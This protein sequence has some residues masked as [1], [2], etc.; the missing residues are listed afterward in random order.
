MDRLACKLFGTS[1]SVLTVPM[2]ILHAACVSQSNCVHHASASIGLSFLAVDMLVIRKYYLKQKKL[3]T[4]TNTIS[5]YRVAT[6]FCLCGQ[7][8][9][10]GEWLCHIDKQSACFVKPCSQQIDAGACLRF[11][12]R[13]LHHYGVHHHIA[14]CSPKGAQDDH[15]NSHGGRL[16]D[17]GKRCPRDCACTVTTGPLLVLGA[18]SI[19]GLRKT[20]GGGGK[21]R[22]PQSSQ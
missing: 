6:Q 16:H 15:G 13:P 5:I 18:P 14:A 10:N 3:C 8:V 9:A 2:L 11:P 1:E 7:T 21:S 17:S 19:Q 20:R 12:T 22:L 4:R